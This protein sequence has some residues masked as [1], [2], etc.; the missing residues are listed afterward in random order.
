MRTTKR[1]GKGSLCRHEV[2]IYVSMH[3]MHP[4]YIFKDYSRYIVSCS[5][6]LPREVGGHLKAEESEGV[7]CHDRLVCT[8][9]TYICTV[10]VYAL[11]PNGIEDKVV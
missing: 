6:T 4:L 7:S 10:Q 2:F 9:R 8:Y 3:C 1:P 5:Q 11:G